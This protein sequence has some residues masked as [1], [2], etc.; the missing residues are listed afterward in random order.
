M[1]KQINLESDFLDF[2][3]LCNHFEVKYLVIGGYAVSIHGYPRSTKDL[4]ICIQ[5]SGDNADKMI[6]VINEFGFASLELSKD[7]FIKPDFITQLGY[8][9]LRIDI[10]ND[11]DGVPFDE[12]W[13][14]KKVVVMLDEPV[15]FIGYN[16]L[17]KVK[18]KAGRP[19]DLADIDKL[20]KR[21]SK[22]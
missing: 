12:A 4:D 3:K 13:I 15:N 19:Q 21:N 17:L 10:I 11:L 6:Q 8:E 2:I 16:E 1:K 20:K 7:D 18:A 14:N 5:L 9:P 22:K